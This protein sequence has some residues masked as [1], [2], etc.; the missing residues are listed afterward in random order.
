MSKRSQRA[1]IAKETV[2]ILKKGFYED[3]KGKRQDIAE[4][5]TWAEDHTKLYRPQ[6]FETLSLPSKGK[7]S[8]HIEL[9]NET[10]LSAASR[11]WAAGERQIMVLN[12]ASA[13]N[14]G[15]GFLNGSQAQE[16]SLA[17]ASGLYHTLLT[18]REMYEY[19]RAQR[20][21]LYSDHM[22]YSPQVP[23][24]RDDDDQLLEQF[25]LLNFMTAPAVNRNCINNRK[26]GESHEEILQAMHQRSER[27]LQAA[28]QEQNTVLVLG[29]WG[30]GVFSQDPR[31]IAQ[32]FAELLLNEGKFAGVFR[33]IVFAVLDP[34]KA[35]QTFRAFTEHFAC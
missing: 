12:F 9:H 2:E 10:S 6:D 30:C 18:K 27:L 13:K 26:G 14:P 35:E 24:F 11:L 19:N 25:Y 17:R 34:S 23:V 29:A 21:C 7:Q 33:K 1:T 22:I 15:G 28:W 8:T 5:Q 31:N 4:A 3:P 32:I 20:T 16:E